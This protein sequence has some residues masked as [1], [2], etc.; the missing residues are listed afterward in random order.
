MYLYKCIEQVTENESDLREIQEAALK[1]ITS[2]TDCVC[3]VSIRAE[4]VSK[5]F[6]DL[7]KDSVVEYSCDSIVSICENPD[8]KSENVAQSEEKLVETK[9]V[10]EIKKINPTDDWLNLI[11][12]QTETEPVQLSDVMEH[13]TI[14]CT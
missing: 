6:K 3:Y 12:T 11:K 1:Q 13:S 5:Q 9:D 7:K 2:T 4:E 8:T 10:A 14:T